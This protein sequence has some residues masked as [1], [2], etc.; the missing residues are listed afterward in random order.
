MNAAD[1]VLEQYPVIFFVGGVFFFPFAM[2][3]M[4]KYYGSENVTKKMWS[5]TL[6]R[7]ALCSWLWL[8]GGCVGFSDICLLLKIGQRLLV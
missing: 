3:N 5:V 6:F 1:I 8:L 7:C 2:Y 4:C